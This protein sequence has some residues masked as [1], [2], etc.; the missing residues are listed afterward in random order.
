ML[1]IYTY[2]FKAILDDLKVEY[3]EEYKFDQLFNRKFRFDFAIIDKK[4]AFEIDGATFSGGRHVRG[5]G[6]N[7]DLV[8][9]FLAGA[10]QWRIFTI[11]TLWFTHHK[12]K[13]YQAHLLYYEDMVEMIKNLVRAPL[14]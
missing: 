4:I 11:S 2:Q 10:Q 7:S 1:N 12:R 14:R 9:Y 6:Y 13:K 8:K 5:K 3:V